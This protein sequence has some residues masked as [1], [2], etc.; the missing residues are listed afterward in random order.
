MIY[1]QGSNFQ[2]QTQRNSEIIGGTLEVEKDMIYFVKAEVLRNDLG[3]KHEHVSSINL[4]GRELFQ[5]GC[6][7]DGGD[8]DCTFFECPLVK[9]FTISSTTG[10]IVVKMDFKEHSKDCDC[11]ANTW[12]CSKENTVQGRAPME[13]VARFTLTPGKLLDFCTAFARICTRMC[14][15][16]FVSIM[17]S[18][19]GMFGCFHMHV[20]ICVLCIC[21]RAR[22]YMQALLAIATK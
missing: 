17:Q 21:L 3:D 22:M 2:T 15:L 7:P 4:D 8:H 19:H 16:C 20:G 14:L 10:T 6:H 12:S 18:F 1:K 11:D 5:D 13:A 9:G